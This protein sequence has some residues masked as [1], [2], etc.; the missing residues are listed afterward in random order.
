MLKNLF[1]FALTSILF[2]P[3]AGL[4]QAKKEIPSF[5]FKCDDGRVFVGKNETEMPLK[6]ALKI[7]DKRIQTLWSRYYKIKPTKRDRKLGR[8]IDKRLVQLY[9]TRE[10]LYLCTGYQL[11]FLHGDWNLS[12]E[13]INPEG[14]GN[15]LFKLNKF[16]T[17]Y[18]QS[19]DKICTISGSFTA[20]GK[21]IILKNKAVEESPTG[22]CQG[23]AI[24]TI[25]LEK[26]V[27]IDGEECVDNKYGVRYCQLI[28]DFSKHNDDNTIL[29]FTIDGSG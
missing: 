26:T 6:K 7:I 3:I 8:R 5:S 23:V 24:A 16:S 15:F 1:V 21:T 11:S 22:S 12:S 19:N 25:G 2:I 13:S 20:N 14:Y 9:N 18:A 28:M 29:Y 4:A 27:D 10:N 17:T